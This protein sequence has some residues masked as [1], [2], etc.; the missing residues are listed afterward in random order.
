MKKTFNSSLNCAFYLSSIM[1]ELAEQEK[2]FREFFKTYNRMSNICFVQCVWDFNR[3][4]VTSREEKCVNNC[5]NKYLSSN[6][7]IQQVFAEDQASILTTG[8]VRENQ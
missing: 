8:A 2:T 5:V 6:K 4:T 7:E 1:A 3:E